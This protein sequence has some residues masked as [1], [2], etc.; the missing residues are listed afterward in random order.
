MLHLQEQN[1]ISEAFR[2]QPSQSWTFYLFQI[3]F[4]TLIVIHFFNL[5]SS[6]LIIAS[7]ISN[8]ISLSM[9]ECEDIEKFLLLTVFKPMT[10]GFSLHSTPSCNCYNLQLQHLYGHQLKRGYLSKYAYDL[11]LQW[12]P[13]IT[14]VVS[15][16]TFIISG[17]YFVIKEEYLCTI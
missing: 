7:W 11:T 5:D 15:E 14:E 1:L 2:I 8:Q 16:S 9:V 13:G 10:S 4:F 12:L 17:S 6:H 3:Y